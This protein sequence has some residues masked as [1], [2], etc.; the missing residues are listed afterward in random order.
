MDRYRIAFFT[1]DWNYD[2]VESTL[3]G[4]RQYVDDHEGVNLCIFD[5]FGKDTDNARDRSEYSIYD[6]V[7]LDQFDG[8]LIQ[9][10]Q[11]VLQSVRDAIAK[12]VAQSG[13]PAVSIDC[14]IE[15]CSV[16]GID[17]RQAQHDIVRHVI[18][19]H[20]ARRLVYL[21]GIL[22]NGSPEARQRLDGFHDACREAN[23]DPAGIEVFRCTWRTSD[24]LRIA[25]RWFKKGLALPDAFICGNDEMA[26]GL[27]EGLQKHG[28]SVPGDVLV[29]GFDNITSAEL[30]RPRLS[31]VSRDYSRMNYCA[32]E[33]LINK[34]KG[35]E[36]RDFIP[37]E[38]DVIY[39]ESCG[40]QE[41]ARP[42]YFRD[43]YF[44]Q[45]RTLKA[46]FVQQEQIAEE[47]FDASDLAELMDSV[48][49]NQAIF[50]C[51]SIYLCINDY[52]YDNYDK[53]LW[54]SDSERFGKEMILAACGGIDSVPDEG[55][56][57]ARF[58]ARYLLPGRIMNDQR[59]L[60]FY[61][62]HYNTYS[63]GYM[64]MNGIS[65]AAKLNLHE[66]IFSFLEIA[67]E[68]VRKKGLLR[69]LNDVLDNLYVH[70]ALTGM[71][72]RFGYER[73]AEQTYEAFLREDGGAQI[74]FVDMDDMKGINDRY[75]HEI[76]DAAIRAAAGLIKQT[77]RAG[78]FT[79]RYGGDEFLVIASIRETGLADALACTL[80]PNTREDLPCRLSLTVGRVEVDDATT[81]TLDE[82]V[83]DADARMY[84]IKKRKK[85]GH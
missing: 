74:L 83:Q 53:K 16:L 9:G 39:S 25:E 65:Q 10:N 82:C 66:S 13:I 32:M 44:Q 58:P 28:V 76:G 43:K 24:G 77:C 71:Y 36:K 41:G 68:N 29:T 61:P 17:N 78:D 48:E 38:Y 51:D 35:V 31:T 11:I 12:R 3:H 4:L 23:L 72:N 56:I 80:E 5:C 55:H 84:E 6:L 42:D 21:T 2:L 46:F 30:S 62:L 54:R 79:M 18:D 22:E 33:A 45:T 50:G 63:I 52:Y 60:I 64:V 40:C 59:F 85:A 47:M 19:E 14:P 81:Q 34:I 26:L 70:D 49:R 15:G 73:F 57:Y 7:D 20:G 37:F 67:I 27:I 69:Q 1:V 75:G 8:L